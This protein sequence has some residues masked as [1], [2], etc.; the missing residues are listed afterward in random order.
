MHTGF[1]WLH[2]T[3]IKLC[4]SAHHLGRGGKKFHC[5]ET[6]LQIYICCT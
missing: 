4:P 6:F 5:V 3:V 1:M 2:A